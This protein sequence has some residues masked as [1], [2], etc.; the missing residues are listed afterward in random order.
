MEHPRSGRSQG[1]PALYIHEA[2][3]GVVV[4]PIHD[5]IAVFVVLSGLIQ[6]EEAALI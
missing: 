2:R 5:H 1:V 6:Y 3:C 4:V